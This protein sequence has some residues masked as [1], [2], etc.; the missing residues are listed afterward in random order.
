[1][2]GIT[3]EHYKAWPE[4]AGDIRER[5][6]KDFGVIE[7]ADPAPV[8]RDRHRDNIVFDHCRLPNIGRKP[9]R[10]VNGPSTN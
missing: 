8:W 4:E 1:M 9:F 2:D 7:I 6:L 3:F 10:P 5:A